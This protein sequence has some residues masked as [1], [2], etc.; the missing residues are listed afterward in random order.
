[1]GR[2]SSYISA[3]P[4]FTMRSPSQK[5]LRGQFGIS[6]LPVCSIGNG[7][8]I[9]ALGRNVLISPVHAVPLLP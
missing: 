9:E 5:T 6:L 4:I 7:D 1:M 3:M 2:G 8:M